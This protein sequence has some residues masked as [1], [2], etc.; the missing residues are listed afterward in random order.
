MLPSRV[1][2]G[3]QLAPFR[4]KINF[5]TSVVLAKQKLDEIP[6]C[7]RRQNTIQGVGIEC[8]MMAVYFIYIFFAPDYSRGIPSPEMLFGI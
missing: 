6:G 3:T 5:D 7:Y 4:Q 2:F 1:A 8:E